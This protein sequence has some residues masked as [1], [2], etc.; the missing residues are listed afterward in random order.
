[1]IGKMW[2]GCTM[3]AGVAFAFTAAL[4]VRARSE[5]EMPVVTPCAASMDTVKLVPSGL[6]L[7][8]TIC[9]KPSWRQ[10]VFGQRQADQAARVA[11]HEIDRFRRDKFGGEYQVAFVLAVFLV[12][13]HDHAPGADLVDDFLYRCYICHVCACIIR[14]T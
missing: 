9:D 5:A 8:R 12:H 3:S 11:D 14:S 7:S 1:M 4:M 10:C 13:Q 6:L 2:P